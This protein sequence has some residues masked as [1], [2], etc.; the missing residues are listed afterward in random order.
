MN[1]MLTYCGVDVYMKFISDFEYY[2]NTKYCSKAYINHGININSLKNRFEEI[3]KYSLF[4][5]IFIF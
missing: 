4:S 1:N 3:E 5:K 2:H